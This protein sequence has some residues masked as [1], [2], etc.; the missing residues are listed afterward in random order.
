MEGKRPRVF[1]NRTLRRIFGPK[2]DENGSR[3]RLQNEQLDSFHRSLNIFVVGV[4]K[5]RILRWAGHVD[6]MKEGR[7]AIKILTGTY[8]G[9]RPFGGPRRRKEGNIRMDL[10]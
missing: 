6:R 9:K 1:E 4:I 10:K 2:S 5:S 8:T 7:S 3:R